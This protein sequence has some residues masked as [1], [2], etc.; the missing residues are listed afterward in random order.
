LA[1]E[2]EWP[3]PKY[4]PGQADH[5][6]A[7]G[8]IA[9]TFTSLQASIEGLYQTA[10]MKQNIP[11]ALYGFLFSNLN[12]EK[13][14]V[15]IRTIFGEQ[16]YEAVIVYAV[17]NLL[18]FFNWC[19]D[20]RNQILHA[21]VYPVGLGGNRE[22]LHLAKRG[23]KPDR[24]YAYMKFSLEQLRFIADK[25]REGIVQSAEIQLHLSYRGTPIEKIPSPYKPFA[26]GP[27]K[28]LKIPK[29]IEPTE[30]P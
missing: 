1:T 2:S 17:N 29:R 11:P 27:P 7:I 25:T 12:E 3:L 19:R 9:V 28:P 8:V 22:L 15:A 30:T 4:N 5:L 20:C 21:E 10:S 18:D 24:S 6:H 16:R 14:I 13:Q 26:A 23:R